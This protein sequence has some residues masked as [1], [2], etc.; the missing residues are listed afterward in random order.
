VYNLRNTQY[1]R[2]LRL[3]RCIARLPGLDGV[4]LN[5]DGEGFVVTW[6]QWS[7]PCEDDAAVLVAVMKI[8]WLVHQI[9]VDDWD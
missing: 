8:Y 4:E 3:G 5:T 6:K 2:L 9:D 1:D 7:K